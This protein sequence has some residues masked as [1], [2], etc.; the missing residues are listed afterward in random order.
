M[1]LVRSTLV[2]IALGTAFG[3]TAFAEEYV[4]GKVKKIDADKGKVTLIHEEIPNLEMPAMTMVF[5]TG[6][7]QMAGAL[8]EGQEIEFQAERINGKLTITKIKE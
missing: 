5:K 1:K 6:E 2:A 7:D 4:K 8:E 3:S